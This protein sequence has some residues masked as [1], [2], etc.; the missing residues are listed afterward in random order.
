MYICTII[1]FKYYL[2]KSYLNVL[3]QGHQ[4]V[5]QFAVLFSIVADLQNLIDLP[6]PAKIRANLNRAKIEWSMTKPHLCALTM[7]THFCE[8]R[9]TNTLV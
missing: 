9:C 2:A 7:L 8:S 5:L 4:N 1:V 3:S 6:Y